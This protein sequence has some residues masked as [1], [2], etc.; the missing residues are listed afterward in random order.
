LLRA[1]VV[2]AFVGA[3]F[4][5][6]TPAFAANYYV[7]SSGAD[8][9]SG[10]SASAPWRTITKVNS[11]PLQAGDVVQFAGGSV[12]TG[13]LQPRSGAAGAPI[14]YTSYG[15]G[16]ATLAGGVDPSGHHSIFYDTGAHDVTV[17]KL[18]ADFGTNDYA[19]TTSRDYDGWM[20]WTGGGYNITFDGVTFA[21]VFNAL[22]VAATDHDWTVRNSTVTSSGLNGFVFNRYNPASTAS[23]S[24]TTRSAAG[25]RTRTSPRASTA[26]T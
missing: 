9:N 5:F 24:R 15:S 4:A 26:R 3:M 19:T 22:N 6:A 21:H 8:T 14:T 11:A 1:A 20:G 25:V 10:T 17:T 2:S 18:I 16:Q 23:R 13:S 7:D 12:F